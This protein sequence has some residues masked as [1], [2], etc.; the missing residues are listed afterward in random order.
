MTPALGAP[1]L[2]PLRKRLAGKNPPRVIV[3]LGDES[4]LREEAL[5]A[6]AAQVLGSA[7]SPDLVT[8]RADASSEGGAGDVLARFF[9]EARTSSLFGGAKVVALREADVAAKADKAAMIAWLKSPSATVTAVLLASDLPADVVALARTAAF[10]VAC[11]ND[12]GSAEN[13]SR[14]AARQ[15]AARGKRLGSDEASTLVELVGDDLGSLENAVE[16]LSLHA[17]DEPAITQASI[18]ALFPGARAGDA[19][20]FAQAVL[21]G[22]TADAFAASSRCFDEGVPESWASSKLARD[23]RSVA[24][25]LLRDFNKWVA[26]ALEAR[27]QL[28]AGTPRGQVTIGRLPPRMVGSVVRIVT[29]R[30]P[31]ALDSIVLLAEETDRGMKSGGPSGRVAIVRLATAVGR[32]K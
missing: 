10:I 26:H 31:E 1:A 7:D 14:F 28:D 21:E 20:E 9:D 22:R 30:R 4:W 8:L 23:E 6:V 32:L 5:R 11:G 25:V 27:R 19:E 18:R 3:A 29:Q 13:P 16:I 2:E 17:G 24:F 12:R 15:A